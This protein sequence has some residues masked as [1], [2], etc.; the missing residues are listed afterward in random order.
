MRYDAKDLIKAVYPDQ[1]DTARAELKPPSAKDWANNLMVPYK[2]E[3]TDVHPGRTYRHPRCLTYLL[4]AEL[5][6]V[7]TVL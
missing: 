4:D 6:K 2:I 1:G 3:S 5:E 7:V